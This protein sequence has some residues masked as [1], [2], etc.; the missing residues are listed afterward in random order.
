M[1]RDLRGA[2]DSRIFFGISLAEVGRLLSHG[3]DR[4][5][6]GE[7]VMRFLGQSFDRCALYQV[8]R[9][10]VRGWLARGPGLDRSLFSS[11]RLALDQP[12]VFFNLASGADLYRGPLPPMSAHL[13]MMRP[14]GGGMP[15][16]CLAVPV[17]IRQRLVCLLYGDRGASELGDL[18]V[19]PYLTLARTMAS[20]LERCILR[21]KSRVA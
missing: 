10:E 2:V 3:E 13:E 11:S 19:E 5:D 21:N 8:R 1:E 17:R 6:V 18:E 16:E 15:R 9:D 4:E 7:V 20:A 14:W 12:S